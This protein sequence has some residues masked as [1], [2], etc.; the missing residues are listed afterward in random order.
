MLDVAAPPM[1]ELGPNLIALLTLLQSLDPSTLDAPLQ[2]ADGAPARNPAGP[3][4]PVAAAG[5]AG[6]RPTVSTLPPC[7]ILEK[8]RVTGSDPLLNHYATIMPRMNG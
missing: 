2:D 1:M 7:S 6:A 3:P 4:A 8:F 5:P